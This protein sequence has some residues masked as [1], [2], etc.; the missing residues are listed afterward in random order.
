MARSILEATPLLCNKA[1][2]FAYFLIIFSVSA[3][4]RATDPDGRASLQLP[5]NMFSLVGSRRLEAVSS[6]LVE[7]NAIAEYLYNSQQTMF[8]LNCVSQVGRCFRGP[9]TQRPDGRV[10]STSSEVYVLSPCCLVCIMLK[11]GT[12]RST[13]GC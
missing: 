6:S 1:F 8:C 9:R 3:G 7:R 11:D 13:G 10:L 5:A 4:S 2:C 12:L